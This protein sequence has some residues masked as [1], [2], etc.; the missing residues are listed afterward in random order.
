MGVVVIGWSSRL[1]CRSFTSW[2]LG[3]VLDRLAVWPSRHLFSWLF[4]PFSCRQL[5]FVLGFHRRLLVLTQ[6]LQCVGRLGIRH[7]IQVVPIVQCFLGV[8]CGVGVF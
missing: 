3:V 6:S 7:S 8:I 5:I 2:S 1:Y 4:W